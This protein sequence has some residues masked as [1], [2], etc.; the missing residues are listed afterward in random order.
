MRNTQG[1]KQGRA[2]ALSRV[3]IT[4]IMAKP[5]L[6]T[7]QVYKSVQTVVVQIADMVTLG[8]PGSRSFCEPRVSAESYYQYQQTTQ[9][10]HVQLHACED[11]FNY[12]MA[13]LQDG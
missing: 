7:L 11:C 4:T 12:E 1:S 5:G 10:K 13:N 9:I 2:R 6:Q 8:G 3:T